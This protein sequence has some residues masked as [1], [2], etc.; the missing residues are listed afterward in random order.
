MMKKAMNK[1]I[2]KELEE[3]VIRLHRR[4][5]IPTVV[6]V[7][8]ILVTA[9]SFYRELKPKTVKQMCENFCPSSFKPLLLGKRIDGK[10]Y[11]ID[12]NYRLTVA[13]MLG[14]DNV[15]CHIIPS[16]GVPFEAKT[17]IGANTVGVT[18]FYENPEE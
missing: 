2:N 4:P 15:L 13:K 14:F 11:L 18:L 1:T 8:D 3:K 16:D 17:F 10:L 12:G 5:A 6:S 9:N 7:S